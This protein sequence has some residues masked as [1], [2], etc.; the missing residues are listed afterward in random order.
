MGL[1]QTLE[2][3]IDP[4]EQGGGAYI[5][6]FDV[7]V[8]ARAVPDVVAATVACDPPGCAPKLHFVSVRDRFPQGIIIRMH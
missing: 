8:D 6:Q 5:P 4:F 2:E 1:T 7:C 3:M